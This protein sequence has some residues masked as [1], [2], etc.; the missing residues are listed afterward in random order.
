MGLRAD[1][2][3]GSYGIFG[4]EPVPPSSVTAQRAATASPEEAFDITI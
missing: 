3:I 4:N 1:V 2:G